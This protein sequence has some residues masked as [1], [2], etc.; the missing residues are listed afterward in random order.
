MPH[1]FWERIA[2]CNP[3]KNRNP[4]KL[5]GDRGLTL[6]EVHTSMSEEFRGLRK[7]LR[8]QLLLIE[9]LRARR[10]EPSEASPTDGAGEGLMQ[11]AAAFFHL[12]Q[13]LRDQ[14]LISP[15]RREAVS[16]FWLQ[17]EQL[18]DRE[19]MQ[20]IREQGVA[21][22]ARLHRAVLARE[23]GARK[24]VVVQVLEPGFIEHGKVRKPAKVILGPED[25]EQETSEESRL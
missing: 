20:I 23:P 22:D 8:K 24:S 1:I 6:Q 10:D 17:L 11:L 13:S 5:E 7:H 12:D 15:Q 19:D 25:Y 16:L 18:L 2:R 3:F 4:A 9:E 14:M 21:F